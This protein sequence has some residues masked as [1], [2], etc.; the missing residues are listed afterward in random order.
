MLSSLFRCS[1][2]LFLSHLL[3]LLLFSFHRVCVRVCVSVFDVCD[4]VSVC[5]VLHFTLAKKNKI[6]ENMW[7][8]WKD[9]SF[10]ESLAPSIGSSF[11][12]ITTTS[13]HEKCIRIS[14]FDNLHRHSKWENCENQ[15]YI[16]IHIH[17]ALHC[18]D[19]RL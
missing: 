6:E 7:I 9:D 16:H 1:L 17:I 15:I 5:V 3:A 19:K 13:A 11:D 14:H 2:I 10:C 4:V 8:K 18:Y 12:F